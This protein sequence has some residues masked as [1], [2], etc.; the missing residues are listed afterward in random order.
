MIVAFAVAA[1]IVLAASAFGLGAVVSGSDL[2]RLVGA[3]WS[4]ALV[5][6][7]YKSG[8]EVS[9]PAGLVVERAGSERWSFRYDYPDEPHANS[10]DEV[11][12][13]SGGSVLAGATVT[14][15]AELDGGAVRIVTER[16]GQDD[17][18]DAT[19]RTTITVG[20]AQL[21]IRKDVR[22]EGDD[23]FFMRNEYRFER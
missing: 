10:S 12:I 4:G 1:S 22:L 3:R 21:T 20:P 9:I 15:R 17:N 6:L 13:T 2:D 5:Y 7:D 23:A 14:E 8:K 16:A 11:E 19:I 18:R